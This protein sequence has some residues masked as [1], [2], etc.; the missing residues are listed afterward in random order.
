MLLGTQRKK[1]I[2]SKAGT[3]IL[4]ISPD[5]PKKLMNFVEK[6]AEL[7]TPFDEDHKI[8]EKY[9][10]WGLKKFMGRVHGRS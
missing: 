8:A 3:V 6:R 10:V 1:K 2:L 4:G 9:G 5:A 7:Y